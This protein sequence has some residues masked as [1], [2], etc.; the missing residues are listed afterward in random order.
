MSPKNARAPRSG[1]LGEKTTMSLDTQLCPKSRARAIVGARVL[2]DP[3]AQRPKVATSSPA[4]SLFADHFN[5]SASSC[6]SVLIRR[7][8]SEQAA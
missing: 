3:I 6:T 4:P 5:R 8:R 2:T 1:T 7:F